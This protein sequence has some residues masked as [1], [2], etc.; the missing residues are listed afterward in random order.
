V[1][2]WENGAGIYPHYH[3]ATDTPANLL[4]GR[5]LASGILKM[6]IAILAEEVGLLAPLLRDGFED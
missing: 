2:T 3:R 4:R 6:D 5:E 1:F